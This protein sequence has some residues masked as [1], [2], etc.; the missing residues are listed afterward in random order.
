MSLIRKTLAPDA[1]GKLL[2]D[3]PDLAG[4][5]LEVIVRPARADKRLAQAWRPGI[6][7]VPPHPARL[8]VTP[9]RTP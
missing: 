7:A 9:R 2:L 8:S 6:D 5:P 3:L 4:Q 1:D